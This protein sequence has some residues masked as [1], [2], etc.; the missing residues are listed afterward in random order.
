MDDLIDRPDRAIQTLQR[1]AIIAEQATEG[2]AAIDLDGI[3][4]FANTSWA[5][6]H[7]YESV[8]EVCEKHISEFHSPH[9]MTAEVLPFMEEVKQRG[10]LCG[11]LQH[12]R[13]DG[14][15]FPAHTKMTAVKNGDG[16][17]VG[18]LIFAV[19]ITVRRRKTEELKR[20]KEQLQQNLLERRQVEEELQNRI[21][22]LDRLRERTQNYHGQL[23][24]YHRQTEQLKAANR[25]M[26][27]EM[28][29]L[30]KLERN[31][32]QETEELNDI[33]EQSG[34]LLAQRKQ[35]DY[36]SWKYRSNLELAECSSEQLKLAK[37]KLLK[38][39]AELKNA[40]ENLHQQ[41]DKLNEAR[42]QLQ[43]DNSEWEK[44]EEEL[45]EQDEQLKQE[46]VKQREAERELQDQIVRMSS[47]KPLQADAPPSRKKHAAKPDLVAVQA[48]EKHAE[49]SLEKAD[50]PPKPRRP[51]T[52]HKLVPAAESPGYRPRN[53]LLKPLVRVSVTGLALIL[54][55]GTV[56]SA[57]TW[58][59]LRALRQAQP[60]SEA[61]QTSGDRRFG[62]TIEQV[63]TILNS[64]Y[65]GSQAR[66]L[67]AD[68]LA[69]AMDTD[70]AINEL[71]ALLDEKPDIAG[72]SHLLLAGLYMDSEL[73]DEARDSKVREHRSKALELLPET[74]D[75]YYLR[76]LDT[77]NA[78]ESMDLAVK[79][80]W[81][82]D[83]EYVE[84]NKERCK[85]LLA[86]EEYTRLITDAEKCLELGADEE[87]F[88]FYAFCAHTALGDYDSAEAA[89]ERILTLDTDAAEFF[90]YWSMRCLFDILVAS[91]RETSF[92]PT[93]PVEALKNP[94]ALKHLCFVGRLFAG[95]DRELRAVWENIEIAGLPEAPHL[96]AQSQSLPPE[97]DPESEDSAKTVV[98]VLASAY[99]FLRDKQYDKAGAVNHYKEIVQNAT[100]L[101]EMMH[102]REYH[103]SMV[104]AAAQAGADVLDLAARWQEMAIRLLPEEETPQV[105]DLAR[106]ILDLYEKK[107]PYYHQVVLQDQMIAW[108]K[109]DDEQD[110]TTPDS[111]GNGLGGKLIGDAVI[112]EDPE[113]GKVL[114]LDGDG[115]WVDCGDDVR[116]RITGPITI[117]AWFK[118]H[119]FDKTYQSILT[120]GN[121]GW[122]LQFDGEKEVV[123]F[124]CTD[125]D[126]PTDPW[127]AI[128]RRSANDGK[129]HHVVCVYDT[130][131]SVLY[132]DGFRE[133]TNRSLPQLT[134]DSS[135]I[136]IGAR[137]SYGT[138]TSC[139]WNG[140]IDD[141]RIY[142]YPLSE[143][144]IRDLYGGAGPELKTNRLEAERVVWPSRL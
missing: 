104:L 21:D 89:F 29:K 119:K 77:V 121:S 91:V 22:E 108:W 69:Q 16:Q 66:L 39:I 123:E 144:E 109:L 103:T 3:V 45:Q 4:H 50:A 110:G 48:S 124:V 113:R 135:P 116:F 12:V 59:E 47:A 140:L 114:M 26:R 17:A 27:Q 97:I 37:Q 80:G 38:Q 142:N 106:A 78:A 52:G 118:A 86:A 63:G 15:V 134:T 127:A 7:G 95:Q 20:V 71:E 19:D 93:I 46:M 9:Q 58:G 115:D 112:V 117:S 83:K 42:K 100:E 125:F 18:F 33:G 70:D 133:V 88:L 11:P 54:L 143:P 44:L 30:R 120:K 28:A 92:G 107:E 84:F 126:V 72:A 90:E 43:N 130:V 131:T 2:I 101:G 49:R 65:V 67:H 137:G 94:V 102:W 81:K 76:A 96:P 6:M 129:W 57:W 56:F 34:S 68:I 60:R 87:F 5:Q 82:N 74:A 136:Q 8:D 55:L 31:L 141:V 73:D 62:E 111:S 13:K 41:T 75:Y 14:D 85:T 40:K 61:R 64:G 32:R 36:R 98:E 25:Q 128:G 10:L 99:A 24:F 53:L 1:L 79:Y 23:Q 51:K 132:L 122:R 105:K 35:I 139:E 138:K